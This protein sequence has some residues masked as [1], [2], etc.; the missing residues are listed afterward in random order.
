MAQYRLR[1]SPLVPAIVWLAGAFLMYEFFYTT[2]LLRFVFIFGFLMCAVAYIPLAYR[3]TW[4]L[5]PRVVPYYKVPFLL[6]KEP[7]KQFEEQV[8]S[9]I[10]TLYTVLILFWI[11]ALPIGTGYMVYTQAERYYHEELAKFG[12][13]KKV[14]IKSI[15]QSNTSSYR[16]AHFDLYWAGHRNAC[17]LSLGLRSIQAG[18]CVNVVF[19]KRNLDFLDWAD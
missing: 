11:L 16:A 1:P 18:D 17:E 13:V 3:L 6:T 12:H 9:Q 5:I 14:Q 15:Y 8:G 19:S 4:L 7:Y 10:A 2:S